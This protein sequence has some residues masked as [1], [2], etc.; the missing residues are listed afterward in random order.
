MAVSCGILVRKGGIEEEGIHKWSPR[1]YCVSSIVTQSDLLLLITP[2]LHLHSAQHYNCHVTIVASTVP[3]CISERENASRIG[4]LASST[5]SIYRHPMVMSTSSR[6]T[7]EWSQH[8]VVHYQAKATGKC[9]APERI[10]IP[11]SAIHRLID[12]HCRL[13]E[14]GDHL[15]K[16]N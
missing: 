11:R 5:A 9:S 12:T 10:A 16:E 4:L 6:E 8:R 15:T 2:L 1:E 14:N 7:K 13:M 3:V